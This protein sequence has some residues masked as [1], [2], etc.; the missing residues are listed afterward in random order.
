[1][2]AVSTK[3][4]DVLTGHQVRVLLLPDDSPAPARQPLKHGMFAS[5]FPALS[6]ADFQIAEFQGDDAG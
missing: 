4:T 5:N 2:S 3:E 6:L 1:M